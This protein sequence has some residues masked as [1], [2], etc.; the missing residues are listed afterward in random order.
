MKDKKHDLD[1][2]LSEALKDDNLYEEPS[3]ELIHRLEK[4]IADTEKPVTTRRAF[5]LSTAIAIAI[6]ASLSLS[7]AV[8]G[9]AI[10]ESLGFRIVEGEEYVISYGF[11]EWGGYVELAPEGGRVVAQDDDGLLWLVQDPLV[12]TDLEEA[13]ELFAAPEYIKLPTYLPEGFEFYQATFLFSPMSNWP[14]DYPYLMDYPYVGAGVGLYDLLITFS[15]GRDFFGFEIIVFPC[16]IDDD[17]FQHADV[18]DC[19]CYN[20]IDMFYEIPIEEWADDLVIIELAEGEEPVPLPP[21]SPPPT[22]FDMKEDFYDCMCWTEIEI[23]SLTT[24]YEF[25]C[26]HNEMPVLILPPIGPYE[27]REG[28]DIILS[29][30][31]TA[32]LDDYIL[33]IMSDF[34]PPEIGSLVMYTFYFGPS[35]RW[36]GTDLD[37]ETLIRMAESLE[38]VRP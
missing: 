30:G 14:L 20:C 6:L 2:I 26:E 7:M 9:G 28:E 12:L 23:E 33:R 38:Y 27:P 29:N 31:Q 4:Q 25:F 5:K 11:H 36:P 15:N 17:P 16:Y 22:T 21:P 35:P 19:D 24:P 13:I 1:A 3:D 18:V 8:F 10:L 34:P 32:W 37:R